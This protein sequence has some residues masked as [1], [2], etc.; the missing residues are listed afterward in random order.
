[1]GELFGDIDE[2]LITLR[3]LIETIINSAQLVSISSDEISEGNK[4]ISDRTQEY[5]SSIQKTSST[6]EELS[7]SVKSNTSNLISVNKKALTATKN[8]HDGNNILN[9]TAIAMEEINISSKK[10][11][12]IINVV[13]DI[14]FQTNLLALNAAIEAARAGEHGKGFSVVATEVRNLAQRSGESSKQIQALIKESVD[15]A[16]NGNSLV[17]NTVEH[18]KKITID[19]SDVSNIITEITNSSNEQSIGI[20]QI[21]LEMQQMDQVTQQN[22]ALVQEIAAASAMLNTQSI[23]L[24]SLTN[25]FILK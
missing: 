2:T 5:S 23:E 4:H 3:S 24:Y 6:I 12:E 13:N 20:T 10:I 22:S 8:V 19:V 21:N 7:A 1:M 18:L 14:A 9:K 15:K 16:I 25:K 11:L 17:K